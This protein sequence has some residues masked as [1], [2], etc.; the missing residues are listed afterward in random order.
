[1]E[2]SRG[3]EIAGGDT[4][5]LVRGPCWRNSGSRGHSFLSRDCGGVLTLGPGW[6]GWK[7]CGRRFRSR[8]TGLGSF[9]ALFAR[10]SPFRRPNTRLLLLDAFFSNQETANPYLLK[11][12][13]TEHGSNIFIHLPICK[14]ME[15]TTNSLP[16]FS[17]TSFSYFLTRIQ[18][19]PLI[20]PLI[21]PL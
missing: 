2:R 10:K 13:T 14:N 11:T 7:W 16:I 9:V 15:V 3:R 8:G 5:L 6:G 4:R 17:W 1:M 12:S 18:L 19:L 21:Q 20:Y